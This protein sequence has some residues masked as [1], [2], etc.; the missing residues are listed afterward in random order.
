MFCSKCGS[1]IDETATFCPACGVAVAAIAAGA[2]A[3][4]IPARAYQEGYDWLTT[5]LLCLF[6]GK[7]GVHRFYTGHTWIGLFQLLTLGGCGI[8]WIVDIIF[9]VTESFVDSEGRPL[10]KKN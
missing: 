4:Q 1:A 2:V 6:L 5:L 10:V 8:F 7:L 9:L 3:Q